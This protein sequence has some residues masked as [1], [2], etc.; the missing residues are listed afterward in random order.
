MI[1]DHSSINLLNFD[2]VSLRDYCIALGEKPFRADQLM[3]WIHHEGV[4]DF[5]QM[6][7]LSKHLRQYLKENTTIEVPQVAREQ[8]SK[9]GTHKWLFELSDGAFIET[10]FIP[11]PHRGTLCISSQVGCPL[12]CVFCATGQMGFKRNLTTAEIIG[13]LWLVVRHLSEDSGRHDR[14]ITNVVFMGMGEPLLNLDAVIPAIRIMVDDF[15]YS[16]S[17]Y[18]V[19]VST[20]GI[21]PGIDRLSQEIDV[22]LAIS[23]HA[24]NNEIR[25]RL[26]PINKKYP[27]EALMTSAKNYVQSSR[28]KTISFEYILI[29]NINDQ[30]QHARQLV[31]L[32]SH[33]RCKANLIPLNPCAHLP[34]EFLPPIQENIDRFR[35]ILIKAGIVTIT[36]R[37]RGEDIAAACGQLRSIEIGEKIF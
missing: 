35:D 21:V 7:N 12:A 22:A 24:P 17:K 15:A 8:I 32:L 28:L 37:R 6:T 1:K 13:Q 5:D 26:M 30:P 20:A 36:R 11:E 34:P 4:T 27:L 23:L 25:D 18:R 31:K 14:K 9:D 19:T 33:I 3:K 29:H 2:R 16:L 10:V